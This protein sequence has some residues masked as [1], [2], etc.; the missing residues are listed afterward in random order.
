MFR[1]ACVVLLIGVMPRVFPQDITPADSEREKDVY[2]IYS[3]ILTNY[4]GSD[5]RYL[6]Q[7]TTVPGFPE[8]P[9]VR[10]PVE[11]NRDFREVLAD[12]ERR[13]APQRQIKPMFSVP[14]PYV[15]LTADE[16]NP[17]IQHLADLYSYGQS[18]GDE[19]FRGV[20]HLF[21]LTDVYLNPSRTLALTAISLWCGGLCGRHD[22]KVYEKIDGKWKE[23]RWVTCMTIAKNIWPN[24]ESGCFNRPVDR[25][26]F[27]L[28]PLVP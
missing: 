8:I 27:P 16:A 1:R 4:G 14:K 28:L 26:C 18:S 7:A 24:A 11:R 22:W 23:R 15:L 10:P 9:C 3:L 25:N 6:I 2:A 17:I 5:E 21:R 13:K 12:Y 20:T 19:R